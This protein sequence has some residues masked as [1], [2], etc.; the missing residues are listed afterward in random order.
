[1]DTKINRYKVKNLVDDGFNS[2]LVENAV[3]TGLLEFPAI[4][5]PERIVI[6][7]AMIP[8]S[9]RKYS[10]K[11][12]EAI[13]FYEHDLKFRELLT[14]VEDYIDE[15]KKFPAVIS[16]DC[17]LYRDMPLVLQMVNVYLNRQIGHFLQEQGCYVIPN[18]RWGDER[19]YI[20]TIPSELPFAFLG[21][22]KHSIVSIGTYGCC[23]SKADKTYLKEGLNAMLNELEP[24]VVLVYGAMPSLVFDEFKGITRFVHYPDWTSAKHGRICHG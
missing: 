5:K 22:P 4:M 24:E 17:S 14:G 13:M 21:I 6:P 9:M 15:I 12:K 1:M 19:S 2:K 23:K 10:D 7:V 3:F 16:P 18:V 8:F 11:H 20:R